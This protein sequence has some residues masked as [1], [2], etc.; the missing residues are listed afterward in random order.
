MRQQITQL[1]DFVAGQNDIRIAVI[2]V[3]HIK[4]FTAYAAGWKNGFIPIDGND[5]VDARFAMRNHVAKR[6]VFCTEGQA[7]DSFDANACV[8]IAF[9]SNKR[10]TNSPGFR[11]GA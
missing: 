4:I 6:D 5:R 7:A 11:T 2:I 3:N 1:H 10:A 9:I 8:N